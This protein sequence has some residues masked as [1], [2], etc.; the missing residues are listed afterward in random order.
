MPDSAHHRSNEAIFRKP[1][2]GQKLSVVN[3]RY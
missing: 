2:A 3:V 1:V